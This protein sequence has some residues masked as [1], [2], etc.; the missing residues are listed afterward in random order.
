MPCQGADDAFAV[1]GTGE[2]SGV[3]SQLRYAGTD[4]H[5]LLSGALDGDRQADFAIRLDDVTALTASSLIL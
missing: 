4:R 1:L 2:F 5:V 3:I